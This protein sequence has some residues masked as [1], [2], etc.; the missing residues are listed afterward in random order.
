M[1]ASPSPISDRE[2]ARA[3]RRSR[4]LLTVLGFG[5]GVCNGLLG[6]AG[7][8]LLVAVLPRLTLPGQLSSPA[9][10]VGHPLG[11]S[12]ERRDILATALAVML[13]V[14]AVSWLFYWLGGVPMELSTVIYLVL[15]AIAGGLLGA[16][17]LGRIPDAVLRKLFAG[18]VVVSGLR[19]LF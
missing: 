7:G 5:A 8:I 18:L 4:I 13:P 14:S 3:D 6:A 17:L 15:P 19:M 2:S 9:V 16:K 1:Q 12:L 11:A 10:A